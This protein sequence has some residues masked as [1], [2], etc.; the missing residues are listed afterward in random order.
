MYIIFHKKEKNKITLKIKN[1]I[2]FT[3]DK[4]YILNST[5]INLFLIDKFK[6]PNKE[7]EVKYL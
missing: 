4:Y 6:K 5:I 2:Y 1:E 7:G 3:F